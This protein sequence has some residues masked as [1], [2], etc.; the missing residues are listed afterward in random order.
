MILTIEI[1][2]RY[3]GKL[4]S[5]IA[6][7]PE[8]VVKRRNSLD[9]EISA[10]VSEYRSGAMKTTPFGEGLDEIRERLVSRL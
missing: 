10:R 4:E 3:I 7:M 1:D 2:D 9:D 8:G 6:S 5:F